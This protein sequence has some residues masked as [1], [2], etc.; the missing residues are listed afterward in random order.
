MESLD[1]LRGNLIKISNWYKKVPFIISKFLRYMNVL[2]YSDNYTILI[3]Y[4]WK[5]GVLMEI[6]LKFTKIKNCVDDLFEI[7]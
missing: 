5:I 2:F 1:I 4:T 6:S 7:Q 3:N